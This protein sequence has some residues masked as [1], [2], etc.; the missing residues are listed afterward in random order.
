MKKRNFIFAS[1][2]TLAQGVYNALEVITGGN[3]N[4]K[5][6][7]AYVN[8]QQTNVAEEAEQLLAGYPAG[9]EIIVLTDLYGGSVNTEFVKLMGKYGIH[10]VSGLSLPLALFVLDG[11]E[12]ETEEMLRKAVEQAKGSVQYCNQVLSQEQTEDDF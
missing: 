1:H 11:E 12:E 4:V 2:G 6:Y 7:S 5:V 10:V 3:E 8:G 9:E